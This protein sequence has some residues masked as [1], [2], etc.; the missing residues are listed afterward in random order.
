MIFN[1]N[2]IAKNKNWY[3]IVNKS[4]WEKINKLYNLIKE[5]KL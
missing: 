5:T 1:I 4:F 2:I 3:K